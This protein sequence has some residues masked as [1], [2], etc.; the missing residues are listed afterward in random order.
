MLDLDHAYGRRTQCRSSFVAWPNSQSK[1]LSFSFGLRFTFTDGSVCTSG[2]E[3]RMNKLLSYND[4]QIIAIHV[5][6][7]SNP[8]WNQADN[9]VDHAI[10]VQAIK[11]AFVD[12]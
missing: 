6:D 7:I 9:D 5:H 2:H 1:S 3:D 10:F 8:S 4:R 12:A 11:I